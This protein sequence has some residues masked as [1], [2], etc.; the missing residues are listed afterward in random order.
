MRHPH[1][2]LKPLNHNNQWVIGIYFDYN[3]DHIALVKQAGATWSQTNR[4]WWLANTKEALN[5]LVQRC[6]GSVW[7][8]YSGLKTQKKSAGRKSPTIKRDLVPDEFKDR[9][10]RMR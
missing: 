8:D 1:L 3:T 2:T 4:C 10:V 5:R 7:V 9:L 6:K